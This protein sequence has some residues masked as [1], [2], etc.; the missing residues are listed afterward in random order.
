MMLF[1][2]SGKKEYRGQRTEDRGQRTEDRTLK[3]SPFPF[4]TASVLLGSIYLC[5][6]PDQNPILVK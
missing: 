5:R 6:G 2:M 3:S 4:N 1:I